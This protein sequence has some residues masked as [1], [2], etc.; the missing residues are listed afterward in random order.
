MLGVIFLNKMCTRNNH[1][2]R[3]HF[4]ALTKNH[5]LFMNKAHLLYNSITKT[6]QKN[7]FT[8]SL[9][10]FCNCQ[11]QFQYKHHYTV[12]YR[13]LKEFFFCFFVFFFSNQR[14]QILTRSSFNNYLQKSIISICNNIL[15]AEL[16]PFF[17]ISSSSCFQ[18]VTQS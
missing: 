1:N 3:Y 4:L 8:D 9:I 12:P 2:E 11:K 16:F 18:L 17:D 13:A 15:F 10:V 6:C 14:L 7:T 5:H